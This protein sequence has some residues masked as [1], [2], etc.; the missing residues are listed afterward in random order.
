MEP[1]DKNRGLQQR[2]GYLRIFFIFLVA[3]ILFKAWHMQIMKGEYYREL[4]EN[5]R[6]RSVIV[7]PLR[8]II[9]DRNGE[10]MAKNVASFNIGLVL[11]DIKD[12]ELTLEKI[13]P[14]TGLS[15]NEMKERIEDNKNYDPFSPLII[16]DNISM[17]EVA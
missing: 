11:A 7:P 6:I 9:Y 2:I 4:A 1:Q 10:V 17:K 15:L 14:V 12:L 13:A 16:K 5:N 8:G 3:I